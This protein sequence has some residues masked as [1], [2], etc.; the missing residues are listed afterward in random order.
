MPCRN[1]IAIGN[2]DEGRL[3]FIRLAILARENHATF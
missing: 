2:F 3:F 1:G